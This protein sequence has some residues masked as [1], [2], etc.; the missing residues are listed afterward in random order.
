MTCLFSLSGQRQVS[1]ARAVSSVVRWVGVFILAVLVACLGG[2]ANVITP[3]TGVTDPATIYV[4]DYGKHAALL[5]P[6]ER[7]GY[8]EWAYG[9]W[10]VFVDNRNA[11]PSYADAFFASDGAAL[12]RRRDDPF[13]PD[14]LRQAGI[15][16]TPV[17]VERAAAAEVMRRLDAKWAAG[18]ATRRDN[19][20]VR[21]TFVR[22]P[23]RYW[24]GHTCNDAVA[25]WLRLAGCRVTGSGLVSR[26]VVRRPARAVSGGP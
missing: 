25:K 4:A 11:W 14:A 20:F 26:F 22:V 23:E 6:H 16:L 7:G 17:T 5:L 10:D 8:V 1:V 13:E 9:D 12:G 3:P 18:V 19:P 2:C 21:L 24:L 15:R